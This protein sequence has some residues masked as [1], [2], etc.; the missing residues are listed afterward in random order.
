MNM[1]AGSLRRLEGAK[2]ALADFHDHTLAMRTSWRGLELNH[3][4]PVMGVP[5]WRGEGTVRKFRCLIAC[6]HVRQ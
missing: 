3:C 1:D 2:A 6:V 4:M 5:G